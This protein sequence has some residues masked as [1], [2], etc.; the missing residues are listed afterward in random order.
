MEHQTEKSFNSNLALIKKGSEVL[1]QAIHAAALFALAQANEHGNIG[2]ATRLIEAM[3]RKHDVKRVEKWFC[4]FGKFGMKASTLIY[5][6]RRDIAPENMDA[7]L[8]KA[9]ETPYYD[10]NEQEHNKA[11]WNGLSLLSSIITRYETVKAKQ[12]QGQEVTIKNAQV[13][14]EVQAILAKYAPVTA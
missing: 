9:D 14:A 4:H 3:G 6:N 13:M 8:N 1:A 2:F 11:T 12:E 10:L 5:R 7:W